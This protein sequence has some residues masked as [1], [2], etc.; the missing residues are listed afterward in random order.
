MRKSLEKVRRILLLVSGCSIINLE[1]GAV[2]PVQFSSRLFRYM[3]LTTR[4]VQSQS[5]ST[6]C[7]CYVLVRLVL[8]FVVSWG[9]IPFVSC[10]CCIRREFSF[11]EKF[12][13]F[14]TILSWSEWLRL[15]INLGRREQRDKGLL[16]ELDELNWLLLVI[17]FQTT[18]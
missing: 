16:V 18:R 3:K 9:E 8:V 17:Q 14:G 6:G 10:S 15:R 2:F 13:S 5:S 11:C 1:S 4:S 12:W 7:P